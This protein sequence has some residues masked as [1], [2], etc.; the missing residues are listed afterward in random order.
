MATASAAARATRLPTPAGRTPRRRRSS[1]TSARTARG[2]RTSPATAA[3]R[4]A[5]GVYS[6]TLDADVSKCARTVSITG[7]APGIATTTATNA[8]TVAVH[9]FD[10]TGIPTDRS[11][12]LVVT[13]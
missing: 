6:V 12:H 13:C 1:R 2:S 8:T 7:D 3:A 10:P 4:S 11:F 5:A 9:T